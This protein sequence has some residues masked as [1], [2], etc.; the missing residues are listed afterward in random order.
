VWYSVTREWRK[1]SPDKLLYRK[2]VHL[3]RPTVQ[4]LGGPPPPA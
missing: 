4:T 3:D 1:R 2:Q